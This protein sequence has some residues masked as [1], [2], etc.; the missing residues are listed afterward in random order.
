[1]S[2]S[3]WLAE[4]T[5]LPLSQLCL[6]SSLNLG[7][8]ASFLELVCSA[9]GFSF[10]GSRLS[11]PHEDA[12]SSQKAKQE[13]GPETAVTVEIWSSPVSWVCPHRDLPSHGGEVGWWEPGGLLPSYCVRAVLWMW[14]GRA[15]GR[16]GRFPSLPASIVAPRF[17]G[18]KE[19]QARSLALLW[20][21]F[22]F[23]FKA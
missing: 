1:M 19:R 20:I 9:L 7:L 10:S 14:G 18:K 6:R 3:A 22:F 21:Y 8:M 23:K 15:V 16:K 12:Y 11:S 4:F 5:T 17:L 2:Q 13:S